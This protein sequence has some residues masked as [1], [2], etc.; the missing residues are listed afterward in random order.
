MLHHPHSN[1][2][3]PDRVSSYASTCHEFRENPELFRRYKV[4]TIISPV[5]AESLS[6]EYL[7]DFV[8]LLVESFEFADSFLQREAD[9]LIALQRG[10][11][12]ELSRLNHLE[13]FDAEPCRQHAVKG[14]RCAAALN[15]AKFGDASFDARAGFYLV[16]EDS[17]DS[18]QA[19][20]A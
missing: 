1:A 2:G 13:G 16:R 4:E 12:T 10:H 17:A 18:A 9:N 5:E 11:A 20:V 14:G 8:Y 15:V 6:E 7:S 3:R 19:V